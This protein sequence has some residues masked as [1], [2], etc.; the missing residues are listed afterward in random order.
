MESV[1]RR[2]VVIVQAPAVMTRSLVVAF[3]AMSSVVGCGSS[4]SETAAGDSGTQTPEPDGS[5]DTGGGVDA[6]VPM[7]AGDVGID[8]S[9]ADAADSAPPLSCPGGKTVPGD[10]ATVQAGLDALAPTG[11][12]LCLGAQAFNEQV[13]LK[14]S[15]ALTIQGVSPDKT[16]L[17]QLTVGYGTPVELTVRGLTIGATWVSSAKGTVTFD[18]VRLGNAANIFTPLRVEQT[19][20]DNVSVTLDRVDVAGNG[21]TMMLVEIEQSW[22]GAGI[23]L[24]MQNSYLHDGDYGFSF[25]SSEFQQTPTSLTLL[26]NTFVN[27]GYAVEIDPGSRTVPVNAVIYNNVLYPNIYDYALYKSNLSLQS[28]YNS[29]FE[30]DAGLGSGPGDVTTDPMLD[31]SSKPPGLLPGSPCLGAGDP[32]HAPKYD[33]WGNPRGARVDIG[34]VQSSK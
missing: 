29:L 22:P 25:R 14:G 2:A 23:T 6:N 13:G 7:D 16:S 19:T 1:N 12:T 17:F 10:F 5:P 30:S 9:L 21:P 20:A 28:G 33:Y 4:P 34:A 31:N 11:G 27:N 8:G 15:K 24:L 26:N 3:V 18:A 32:T